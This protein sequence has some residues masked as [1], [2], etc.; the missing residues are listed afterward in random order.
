M[1]NNRLYVK[2]VSGKKVLRSTCR[3]IKGIYYIMGED[4]VFLEGKWYRTN[5]DKVVFDHAKE[6][7]LLA[8]NRQYLMYGIVKCDKQ[9]L[10]KG[11]F[12]PNEYKNVQVRNSEGEHTCMNEE[13]LDKEYFVEDL[14]TGLWIVK[15]GLS[16]THIKRYSE[17]RQS[18]NATS[19][20]YN[21]EENFSFHTIKSQF[22][23]APLKVPEQAQRWA[24]FL[25]DT[26]WG[27]EYETAKGQIPHRYQG[28]LGLQPCRDGSLHGGIEYVTVPMH[29]AKG[30]TAIKETCKVLNKYTTINMDCSLHIHL[31]NISTS[32]PALIAYYKLFYMIQDELYEMF[33]YFKRDPSGVK[34]KNYCKKLEKIGIRKLRSATTHLYHPYIEKHYDSI[35]RFLACGMPSHHVFNRANRRL[36]LQHKW[37]IKSRYHGL[38]L[39]NMFFSK[40]NTVEFRMHEGTIHPQKVMNFLFI[41][42]AIIKYAE[43]NIL[44]VFTKEKISL[45]EVLNYYKITFKGDKDAAFLSEYLYEY[46]TQR[47]KY[48]NELLSVGDR[49][50]IN[51]MLQEDRYLFQHD[52]MD[53]L[54]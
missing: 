15:S 26:T 32:R 40:R 9:E 43:S 47:K 54:F 42:N 38:N 25:G 20:A 45:K 29:G 12:T 34:S 46:Y 13:L 27:I 5:T 35:F 49:A 33:P 50:G 21:A 51:S 41:C 7:W 44:R 52:G 10:T 6:K 36:H 18:S 11:Y 24:R 8:S 48:F 2:S 3:N 4:C 37:N 17:I 1:P 16:S 39:L 22:E 23:H 31:G 30:L 14:Q 53:Y 28:L 19:F